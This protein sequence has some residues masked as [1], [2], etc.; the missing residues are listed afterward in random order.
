MYEADIS[1]LKAGEYLYAWG[2]TA[3]EFY[4]ILY[5]RMIINDTWTEENYIVEIG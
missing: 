1:I 4:I 2:N 3:H 5:G